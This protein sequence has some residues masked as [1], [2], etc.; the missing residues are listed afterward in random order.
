MRQDR[1]R[2]LV[3]GAVNRVEAAHRVLEHHRDGVAAQLPERRLVKTQKVNAVEPGRTGGDARG[4][5][6]EPHHGGRRQRLARSRLADDRHRLTRAHGQGD[7]LDRPDHPGRRID[8]DRQPLHLQNGVRAR[9]RQ[10]AGQHAVDRAQP[11]GRG[12]SGVNPVP[13]R[14][15]QKVHRK[16]GDGQRRAG[17]EQQERGLRHRRA[18]PADHEPPG[19]FGRDHAEAEKGEPALQH[20]RCRDRER[21]LHQDRPGDVRQHRDEEDAQRTRAERA[22]RLDVVVAACRQ[23]LGV[24]HPHKARQEQDRQH[25]DQRGRP[26]PEQRDDEKRE[27]DRREAEHDVHTAQREELTE[28]AEPAAQ[29]PEQRAERAGD[30]GRGEGDCERGARAPDQAREYV[31]AELVAPERAARAGAGKASGDVL[32]HRVGKVQERRGKRDQH[33]RRDQR[34]RN[35]KPPHACRILGSSAA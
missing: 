12:G 13:K 11:D 28:T 20:H 18:R 16:D 15:A 8:L 7:V 17:P 10:E 32:S 29:Q 3:A 21:Q 6:Q 19:G 25:Q 35:R 24:G 26:R 30:A 34:P 22:N 31:A 2:H 9:R 4:R 5:R 14:V 1:L 33:D 27:Q 23:D